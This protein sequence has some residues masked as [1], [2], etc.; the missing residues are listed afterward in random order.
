MTP[1]GFLADLL[2]D[3]GAFLAAILFVAVTAGI[4]IAFG[5]ST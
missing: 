2:D 1:S 4:C 5:A 3:A